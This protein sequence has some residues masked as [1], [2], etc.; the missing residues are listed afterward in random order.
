VSPNQKL[1]IKLSPQY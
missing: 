1:R